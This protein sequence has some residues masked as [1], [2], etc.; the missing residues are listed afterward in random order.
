MAHDLLPSCFLV[1]ESGRVA[2]ALATTGTYMGWNAGV[3]GMFQ[4]VFSVTEIQK[5]AFPL[6]VS[7]NVVRRSFLH[8]PS[9]SQKSCSQ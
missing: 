2:V 3:K 1:F 8:W 7:L 6:C 5:K 9:E 4:N